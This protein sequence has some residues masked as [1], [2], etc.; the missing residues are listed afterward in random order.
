MDPQKHK[1]TKH[2]SA[3]SRLTQ[4]LHVSI[5]V[6]NDFA[7]ESWDISVAF[8]QK[9]LVQAPGEDPEAHESAGTAYD[10]QSV[11]HS[12]RKRLEALRDLRLISIHRARLVQ[13]S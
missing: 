2:S 8:L 5:C 3:A 11:H 6:Q 1:L 10:T 12:P 13:V 7:I 4:R 9:F